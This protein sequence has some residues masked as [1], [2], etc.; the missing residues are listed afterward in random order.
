MSD[1]KVD[2]ATMLNTEK[3]KFL[4]HQIAAMNDWQILTFNGQLDS[5]D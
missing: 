3:M 1:S 4:I 5:H 2:P